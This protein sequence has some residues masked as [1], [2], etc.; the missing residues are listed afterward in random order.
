VRV[1]A[2]SK[3]L[4][5]ATTISS[6]LPDVLPS[7]LL[8]NEIVRLNENF[9]FL[10]NRTFAEPGEVTQLD[11][12]KNCFKGTSLTVVPNIEEYGSLLTGEPHSFAFDFQV[13]PSQVLEGGYLAGNR[14]ETVWFRLLLCDAVK[15]GFCSPFVETG[16]PR[17]SE[18][19]DV[20]DPIVA[21]RT[22]VAVDS[23]GYTNNR[24]LIGV[25][26]GFHV[27][28][29]YARWALME[30]EPGSG[31]FN[32]TMDMEIVLPDRMAGFYFIIAHA[33]VFVESPSFESSGEL[34]RVDVADAVPDN[35][36]EF[37]EPPKIKTVTQGFKVGIGC[38]IGVFLVV[39]LYV[40][41][42]IIRHRKH[43][44]MQL[45]QA[46][47]L[48]MLMGCVITVT[49]ASFVFMPLQDVFCNLRGMLVEV[50]LSMVAAILVGRVW[51]AYSTL[52]T[53][54]KIGTS[55]QSESIS[56]RWLMAPLTSI[57]KC[58]TFLPWCRKEK[59]QTRQRQRRR[60][61]LRSTVT[62]MELLRL[63]IFLISP[64]LIVQTVGLILYQRTLVI[65]LADGGENG[66]LICDTSS[67]WPTYVG[68]II[69]GCL[70]L[71]AVLAAWVARDLPS[72]LNEKSGIFNSSAFNSVLAFLILAL[73]FITDSPT[74]S[75][76]VTSFLWIAMLL[77]IVLS[78]TVM[79]VLPKIR[80]VWSG[81][82]VVISNL[83]SP[84]SNVMTRRSSMDAIRRSSL[85]SN[86]SRPCSRGEQ[87]EAEL[88]GLPVLAASP[89]NEK[90]TEL[91][92]TPIPEDEDTASSL[93]DT[94]VV[95]IGANSE[96]QSAASQHKPFYL[97]MNEP[98][99]RRVEG[100]MFTL[101]DIITAVTVKSLE[102][103]Q[104][105]LRDWQKL[106]KSVSNLHEDLDRLEF[107]WT[108]D[109]EDS[110]FVDEKEAD[111]HR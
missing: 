10:N 36:I 1:R 87:N 86:D 77:G 59:K 69:V 46:P 85:I 95:D 6:M 28:T 65:D 80:R 91:A 32:A 31:I 24:T 52:S 82:T 29:R 30:Q 104:I 88:V 43:P 9:D 27:F 21:G 70:F 8:Q 66:R 55:R 23:Y 4:F 33:I 107:M 7:F 103:H 62:S 34:F 90:S 83:L 105:L 44:V 17:A 63:I 72:A 78:T 2:N 61:S 13:T 54:L 22:T 93:D 68:F 102:G 37:R 73:V 19:T 92:M 25:K 67:R 42:F 3:E 41:S 64:Q 101:K 39:E 81:E 106:M 89:E 96:Q 108:K 50:P 38:G 48:A 71:M 109:D 35:V 97:Q 110:L 45:A 16:G 18:E 47:F 60:N 40:I 56:E 57:A 26:E 100:E 74:T 98:P 20:D 99:P 5:I 76:N 49:A 11:I 12:R 84:H 75:P 14:S 58:H 111:R 79:I 94:A 53:A 15:T 51:R